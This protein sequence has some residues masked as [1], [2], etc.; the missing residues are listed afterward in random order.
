ME[1]NNQYTQYRDILHHFFTERTKMKSDLGNGSVRN[2]CAWEQGSSEVL[3]TNV[4]LL[5]D[6]AY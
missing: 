5:W 3:R 2:E 1:N 4:N 6:V